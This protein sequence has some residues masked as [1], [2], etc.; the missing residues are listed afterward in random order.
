MAGEIHFAIQKIITIRGKGNPVLE[1]ATRT[2]LILK[3]ID[4]SRWTPMSPD[5]AAMLSKVK[6][7]ATELGISI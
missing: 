5:D 6:Q 7:A 1:G 4:A 3:G 2:K